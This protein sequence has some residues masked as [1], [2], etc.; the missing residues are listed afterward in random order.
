MY[1]IEF[2]ALLELTKSENL[3]VDKCT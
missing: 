2:Q 3:L 1:N